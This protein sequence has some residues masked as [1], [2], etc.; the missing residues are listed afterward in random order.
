MGNRR[1]E[2]KKHHLGCEWRGLNTSRS[3]EGTRAVSVLRV[4]ADG[5]GV[6]GEK[7]TD[8]GLDHQ[9]L[10]NIREEGVKLDAQNPSLGT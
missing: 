6:D 2:L 8:L 1:T 5:G 9:G 10:G 7:D 3:R 4:R